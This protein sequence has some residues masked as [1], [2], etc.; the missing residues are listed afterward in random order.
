MDAWARAV[1]KRERQLEKWKD[2]VGDIW[3]V[4]DTDGGDHDGAYLLYMY[5][6]EGKTFINLNTGEKFEWYDI[7]DMFVRKWTS[8]L[9]R[10][11]TWKKHK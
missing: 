4:T 3:Y 11:V 2:Y 10:E 9:G 7:A 6:D 5:G 1:K 8:N